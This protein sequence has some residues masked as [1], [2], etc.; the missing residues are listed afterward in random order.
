MAN[1]RKKSGRYYLRFYDKNRSPQR[2]EIALGA[3]RKSAAE[4]WQ[5][6]LEDAFAKGE[7]DPW[8]GGWDKET[9]SLSDAIG[10]FL[11][12]KE[13]AGLRESTL[14]EYESKL[15]HFARHAP[16]GAM[17]RD[18]QSEHVWDYMMAKTDVGKSN[19]SDPSNATKRNRY[20]QA[21]MFFSWAEEKGLVDENPSEAVSKPKKR[22]KKQPYFKTREDFE[23][24]LSAIDAHREDRMGKP[25]PTP[26]HEYIKNMARVAVGTGLRCGELLNLLWKD[27]DLTPGSEGPLGR[28]KV[29]ARGDFVPKNGHERI[30]Q[31]GRDYAFDT[32]QAMHS[33]QKPAPEDP[34]FTK[35]NGTQPAGVTISNNWK[36]YLRMTDLPYR[37]EACFHT[38]RHTT[39]S[40]L[41]M[42]GT[43]LYTVMK[44]LGH[45]DI[46][47]TQKYA[48]LRPDAGG[49]A[50]M[51]VFGS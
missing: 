27:I 49:E 30:V 22:S 48:H 41:V 20:L 9:S 15:R 38:T 14:G 29:R 35:E 17:M 11:K 25:G 19:E 42:E 45:K 6:R 12:E 2:K 37:E 51:A 26:K 23:K 39:A 10:R 24:V 40:W 43:P 3:T 28:L 32:L 7:Y 13:R 8:N 33:E 34:V 50:M 46:E 21:K 36:D 1:L 47:T 4:E 44:I 18:V 5:R 31:F 16:T